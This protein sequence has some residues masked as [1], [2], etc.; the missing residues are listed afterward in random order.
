[1]EATPPLQRQK[2]VGDLR[3]RIGGDVRFD[4]LSR[5][6]YATDASIYQIQPIGVV[7]PR[8]DRDIDAVIDVCSAAGVPVLARGG[9]TSQ[10]G[11]TVGEAVVVDTSVHLRDI[12]ALDVERRTATVRP[13]IVLADLNR[14]LKRHGLFFPVDPSTANRATIGGMTANNSSGARSIRYG[15]MVHNVTGID[16]VLADGT[17]ARFAS[18]TQPPAALMERVRAIAARERSEIAERFPKVLRRVGGYNLDLIERD[19]FNPAQILVGSEGTLAFFTSIDLALQPLP[20]YTALGICCFARFYDAMASTKELVT[21]EP[22]AV[23]LIDRTMLDL[24]L[25][26]PVFRPTID[27]YIAGEPD[28]VLLVEFAGDD[29]A[30]LAE[31]VRELD[32]LMTRLGFPQSVAATTETAGQAEVWNLRTAALNI[33]TSMKGDSKPVSIIEDCAVPLEH[34][35][36]YT[37]RL[38]KIFAAHGTVGTFYAHASVGC[39]HVRPVL[40]I[41]TEADVVKMRAIA[42]EAFAMVREFGGS[43]SG[44][45]GDGI[46]RSEFHAEMFGARIVRAFED[47]KDAFDPAGVL[48]PGKIVR[49]PKMDDRTLFRYGPDYAA[50]PLETVL[51][52]SEWGGFTAAIEMCNN[53]GACR[54]AEPGVMCPSYM[55]T[56]EEEHVVRGRANTLRLAMTGQLGKEALTSQD[57]YDA[58]DLC[59]GCKGCRRECPTGVDMAKMK[60]EFL[61]H[62]RKRHGLRLKDRIV[63][64]LPRL[65]PLASTLAPLANMRNRIPGLAKLMER[66]GGIDARRPLPTWR[67]DRFADDREARNR[68]MAPVGEVVLFVDTFNRYFEVDVARA[69]LR[70]L[71]AAGYSVHFATPRAN[72]RPLCCGRTYLSAGLVEDA[73]REARRTIAALQP[74][75]DR[76]VPVVGLEPSCLLTLRDEFVSLLPGPE[77]T[78]LAASAL[79]FEEFIAREVA[80]GRWSLALDALPE[81]T[82]YVHGHCHQKAFGAMPAVA[83]TLK[84]VP[85]LDVKVIESSCCGMAGTFGYEREH[86]DISIAMAEHALLPAVREVPPGALIVTDGISCRHQIADGTSRDAVHVAQ[87]LDAA[88]AG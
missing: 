17:R 80:A 61:A 81:K 87:V 35:A 3:A 30:A 72:E 75:V 73:R 29:P 82:A 13:G 44:E 20:K 71:G 65:A 8:D 1:M 2:L 50:V 52:W 63:A 62:Y 54:K 23:E 83:T 42:E 16:A 48:N 36:E 9:G 33:M 45:H 66:F 10:C 79:L 39:L 85:D 24:A 74:Y 21:L 26:S 22:V 40:D 57:V 46:V 41:K 70:V 51:D 55:V 43:H 58:M 78:A 6:L 56:H 4:R 27:K 38:N 5:G 19:D 88:R 11:Q 7:I 18:D 68:A 34:L 12:M 47:V 67:R 25:R 32:R 15:N 59:V 84:L 60:I 28:A 14:Q 76:G 49:A 77:S 53:N 37:D 31:R 86:Y 64:N 69:A